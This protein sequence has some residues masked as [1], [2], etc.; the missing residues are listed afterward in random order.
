VTFVPAV[1]KVGILSDD[2]K[3]RIRQVQNLHKDRLRI[4]RRY[5]VFLSL[6]FEL[7]NQ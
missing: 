7:I 5:S 3:E 2:D 1:A 6:R 4:P